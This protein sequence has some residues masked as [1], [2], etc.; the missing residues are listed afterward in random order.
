[1]T[2]TH[3]RIFSA[4][5]AKAIKA[6]EYGYRNAIMY[7][8]PHAIAGAGNLCPHAS[9]GCKAACLG[10]YSGQAGM[11]SRDSDLNSV[12]K[13]RIDKAQQ[14]MRNRAAFMLMV[15]RGIAFNAMR[16]KREKLTLAVRLNGSSDIAFEGVAL[17]LSVA[18]AE[19]INKTANGALE[20]TPGFYRNIFAVFPS[21]QFLDYTKN[22]Q[23]MARALPPNYHLTFSRSESNDAQARA[24]LAS[25]GN[26]AAVF[27][28]LPDT[29]AG[30]P[31]IGR[32]SC[33]ERV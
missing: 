16:A 30:A 32:A 8:A 12:R 14:F 6:G 25:G 33:R 17:V 9:E 26:V 15:A 24:V 20:V 23:R 3:A 11:V 1:M 21:I 19:L 29:Y 2:T 10:Y 4:T 22:P 27:D 18:D 28:K 31:E 5:S 13:S 7:L